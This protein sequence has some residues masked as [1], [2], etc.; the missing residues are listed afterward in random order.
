MESTLYFIITSA[1]LYSYSGGE[2]SKAGELRPI[3][4][5][6]TG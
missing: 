6:V 4:S 3:E 1:F 5:Y 2:V